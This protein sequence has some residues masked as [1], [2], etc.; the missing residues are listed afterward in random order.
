MPAAGDIFSD[1][2]RAVPYTRRVAMRSLWVVA[3]RYA[4][5]PWGS[6]LGGSMDYLIHIILIY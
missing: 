1:A 3:R 6:Y 2:Q 4:G 5:H